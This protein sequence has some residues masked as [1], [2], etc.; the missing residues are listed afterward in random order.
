DLVLVRGKVD[1]QRP[2][3]RLLIVDHQHLGHCSAA[4]AG[5][6]V[7]ATGSVTRIVRPPPG[8]SSGV[9]DP[10]IAVRKP[11]ATASPRPTPVP[12]PRSASRSNGSN[13]SGLSRSGTP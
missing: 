12:L 11:L 5:L 4:M 13:M 10:P 9:T 3:D 6:A 7:V 8:V 1:P 2:Q